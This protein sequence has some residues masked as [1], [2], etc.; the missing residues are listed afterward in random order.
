MTI[1]HDQEHFADELSRKVDMHP[2]FARASLASPTVVI[3]NLA[4]SSL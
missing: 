4:V 3:G 2:I 1:N